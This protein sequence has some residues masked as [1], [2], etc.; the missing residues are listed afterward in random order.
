MLSKKGILNTNLLLSYKGYLGSI[1]IS[2]EDNILF[3]KVLGLDCI[4]ISYEG[5][6]L[7]ELQKEFHNGINHYLH[8]CQAEGE[9]PCLTNYVMIEKEIDS[10]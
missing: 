1:K 9:K 10:I 6:N 5:K 7:T 2:T 3:G 4:S 8:C